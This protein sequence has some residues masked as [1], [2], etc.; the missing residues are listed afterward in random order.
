MSTVQLLIEIETLAHADY[1]TGTLN[2]G[3]PY[4]VEVQC[5]LGP[6]LALRLL[7]CW[8]LYRCS[9]PSGRQCLPIIQQKPCRA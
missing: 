2:S 7:S 4:L 1:M 9:W 6:R 3:I 8:R 5:H